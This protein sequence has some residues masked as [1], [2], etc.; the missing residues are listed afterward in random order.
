VALFGKSEEDLQKLQENLD[1]QEK[2]LKVQLA[3]FERS[4]AE[5]FNRNNISKA[6]AEEL[7]KKD[8]KLLEREKDIIQRELE[9][10]NKF[11][12]EQRKAFKEA[13]EVQ[14]KELESREQDINT[15]QEAVEKQ[16]ANFKKLEGELAQKERAHKEAELS[17]VNGFAEKNREALREV[18]NS[19]LL[20]KKREQILEERETNL[21]QKTQNLESKIEKLRKREVS[22]KESEIKR[23]EGFAED[24]KKMDETLATMRLEVIEEISKHRQKELNKLEELVSKEE[25]TRLSTLNE[26]LSKLRDQNQ[27]NIQKERDELEKLKTSLIDDKVKIDDLDYQNQR[28][29]SRKNALTEREENL[30]IELDALV[31][32]RKQSFENEKFSLEE[33]IGRLRESIRTSTALVSNFKEL[34]QKLG[35][36]DPASVLL[37]LKTYEEEIKCLREDMALRPTQEM[38]GAFDRL[39]SEQ[40]ELQIA[41]ERLSEENEGLRSS[42]LHQSDLEM[43]IVELSD[44][45]KSLLRRYEAVDAD[46]NRLMEEMKRLQASYERVQD[47][48][49]RILDIENPYTKE[50]LDRNEHLDM[51]ATSLRK[52]QGKRVDLV[53]S[54][55]ELSDEEKSK[56]EALNKVV[57]S[58]ELQWLDSINNSC[59]DYGLKFSRRILHAFHTALKTSE[60]SLVTVLAGVSGT[61]KSEL[62]RLYSHFGGINFLPLSVQPNWDSQESMLGFFNSIDNKFDA[63][64][65]LR[66]LAQ[67]QKARSEDYPGLQD[68]V[69]LILLDEMNLAHVEL[70][71]AEFLSKLELRRGKKGKDLPKLEVKLGAGISHYELPLGRNVLWA[72]TMNQDETTKS[73]SDK[74]LDRGIV[75]NFPRPT[76]LERRR[77]LKPLAKK[78]PLLSRNV[79]ESWWCKESTFDDNKIIPFK[80]FIEEMNTYLSMVGRA[81]GHRVWQSIEY[82]MANY[83]DVLE[84]QRQNDD[85]ALNKAM[86]IAFED[87]LVQKVMP[88]LRGIET[89]GKSKSEC[90][91]KIR[92]QLVNDDY[93]I[94]DDFDL[95]CGELGYGQFIWNSANYLNNDEESVSTELDETKLDETKKNIDNSLNDDD[96]T[97]IPKKLIEY[98]L[99]EDIDIWRLTTQQIKEVMNCGAKEAK[100]LKDLV[101]AENQ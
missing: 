78:V 89:R 90:L 85:I 35:G 8:A 58:Y 26:E 32:V 79:W 76:T 20:C 10:K 101:N 49:A 100:R 13:I 53:G 92:T 94:I 69:N 67:S 4:K 75:I 47:R 93:S 9:A 29:Q 65:V 91:D 86:K 56:F 33:E 80:E 98:A 21:L 11:V 68:T 99:N 48:E 2:K 6:K 45:N 44:K 24:K 42:A 19:E 73:L 1:A 30:N 5:L 97:E 71:F 63:Q 64:P 23:E 96:S 14:L 52:L 28:L 27:T 18:E 57:G 38:Q 66:L 3:V 31:L 60:W 36:E 25:Q 7:T 16:Y 87:Q 74:V 59:I 88:K 43:Q 62:P 41:C 95:A 82:Y 34:K 37:K 50:I 22:V 17:A 12:K 15:K 83:P 46:N 72:G 51:E 61:G 55:S 70:Y 81:L 77:Q 39:K 84:A 54:E 40:G